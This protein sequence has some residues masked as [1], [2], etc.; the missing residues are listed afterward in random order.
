MSNL[1][2]LFSRLG[3]E[4]EEISDQVGTPPDVRKVKLRSFI[5]SWCILKKLGEDSLASIISS[6]SHCRTVIQ[7]WRRATEKIYHFLI[8]LF[9]D[10]KEIGN[11]LSV[12]V[13]DR[14]CNGH[15]T[16]NGS[17]ER[18]VR[19]PAAVKGAKLAGAGYDDSMTRLITTIPE[20]Y[21]DYVE[22][23]LL[24]KAHDIQ[25]L[26][27]MKSRCAAARTDTEVL[28][29]TDDSEGEGGEDTG[30]DFL[31]P[32]CMCVIASLSNLALS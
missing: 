10:G 30:K 24:P 11:G 27:R 25:Y 8:N 19:L 16:S 3:E 20:H 2:R 4:E 6:P 28:V 21:S 9:A 13:T 31:G 22:K 14:N 15:I 32:V 23:K 1:T 7:E 5:A 17:F 29:L 18:Q 26:K 12:V